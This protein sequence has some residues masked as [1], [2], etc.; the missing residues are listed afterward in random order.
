MKW[1]CL[2]FTSFCLHAVEEAFVTYS[3]ENYFPLMEVL[4]DSVKAFSTRPV[5]AFGINAD[6]PF[7]QTT[8]PF[9]IKKRIDIDIPKIP[10]EDRGPQTHSVYALTLMLIKPKILLDSEIQNGVYVDADIVLNAGCDAL[11][12]FCEKVQQTPLSPTYPYTAEIP[13][14]LMEA[15]DVPKKMMNLVHNPIIVF[16]ENCRPFLQ[17][18]L[19]AD[20]KYGFLPLDI[21]DESIYNA[22]LWKH[23]ATT[24][25]SVC[26]PFHPL[27]RD[28]IWGGNIGAL[29][30]GYKEVIGKIDFY[31]FH[32]CKTAHF[33]K[34]ILQ[35]L[36]KK[37][38]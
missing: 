9:L 35:E 8:Y 36:I 30:N 1:L 4:L 37:H 16:S 26:D 38:K 27:H 10:D 22:L 29:Q 13:K 14:E 33:A 12:S 28:Y 23:G 3:T 18:W 21:T 6:V 32:G 11:F 24:A 34:K 31:C 15:M 5:V 20:E 17:E 2:F 19:E 7:S 25:L